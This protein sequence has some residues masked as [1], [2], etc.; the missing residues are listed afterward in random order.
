MHNSPE[1]KDLRAEKAA[2][3]M[4]K[5]THALLMSVMRI[6]VSRSVSSAMNIAATPYPV[7]FHS[8]AKE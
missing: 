6:L 7:S 4:P 8:R 3:W 5:S 2:K 1:L